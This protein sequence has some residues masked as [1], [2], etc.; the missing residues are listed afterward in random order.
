MGRMVRGWNPSRARFSALAQTGPGAHPASCIMDTRSFPGVKSSQGLTLPP[1]PL[2][3]PWSIKGMAIPLL[4]QWAIRPVQS[5]ST[6][7]RVY[8]A[9]H[10]P[11]VCYRLKLDGLTQYL[12]VKLSVMWCKK[13]EKVSQLIKLWQLKVCCI[14]VHQRFEWEAAPNCGDQLQR[15]KLWYLKHNHELIK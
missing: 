4:P 11:A 9:L 14:W 7:T 12:N 10:L 3:V 13:I 6:C 8:F 2:P 1:H 5:L 15:C